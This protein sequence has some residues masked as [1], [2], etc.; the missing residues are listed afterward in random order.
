[1][2]SLKDKIA[3][4]TGAGNKQSIGYAT[5][6]LLKEA[7]AKHVIILDK[8]IK[9][10]PT[11]RFVLYPHD[12]TVGLR[13]IMGLRDHIERVYGP[14]NVLVNC[15]GILDA[16]KSMHDYT[17]EEMEEVARIFDV[18]VYA[19]RK[20]YRAVIPGMIERND[21]CVINVASIAGLDGRPGHADYAASK[22]ALVSYTRSW[23]WEAALAA[24]NVRVNAVA[25]GFVDTNM[26]AGIPEDVR[27][28]ILRDEVPSHQAIT[29]EEVADAIMSLIRNTGK[30]GAIDVIDKRRR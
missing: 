1:M 7:G 6:E 23:S 18:N 27:E 12:V 9:N 29:T 24:P 25:P 22:A 16:G 20:W 5:V 14:I 4:V 13:K 8:K 26:T 10:L 21:G 19:A 28:A 30:N 15:A 3:V 17:D 11:K 2:Y